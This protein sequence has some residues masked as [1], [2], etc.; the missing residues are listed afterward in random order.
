M[1][2]SEFELIARV[3]PSA[4]ASRATPRAAKRRVYDAPLVCMFCGGPTKG[5]EGGL[6]LFR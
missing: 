4:M 1:F 6:L 5:G 2:S 3:A